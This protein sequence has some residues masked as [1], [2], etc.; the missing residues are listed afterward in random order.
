MLI[1]WKVSS[2]VKIVRTS[3]IVEGVV[4]ERICMRT[5]AIVPFLVLFITKRQRKPRRRTCGIKPR[6]LDDWEAA[7]TSI[8]SSPRLRLRPVMSAASSISAHATEL[9]SWYLGTKIRIISY[10]GCCHHELL[11]AWLLSFATLLSPDDTTL[12]HCETFESL[13]LSTFPTWH[14]A[15]ATSDTSFTSNSFVQP[16]V[17]E[18]QLPSLCWSPGSW[19]A[20]DLNITATSNE[21]DCAI[22]SFAIINA[23]QAIV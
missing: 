3:G 10:C 16:A 4:R 8:S 19:A 23:H 2:H 11:R 14:A 22:P 9:E 20:I 12:S 13:G 6:S 18:Y 21:V 1:C 17:L 15:V 7:W 5:L